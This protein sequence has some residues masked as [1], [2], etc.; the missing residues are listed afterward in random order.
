MSIKHFFIISMLLLTLSSYSAL[1]AETCYSDAIIKGDDYTIKSDCLAV[2]GDDCTTICS[3][4][5]ETCGYT[6]TQSVCDY[7]GSNYVIT[8]TCSSS[9]GTDSQDNDSGDNIGEGFGSDELNNSYG[10]NILASEGYLQLCGMVWDT[11]TLDSAVVKLNP[12]C[13]R[14]VTAKGN[15]TCIVDDEGFSWY[16]ESSSLPVIPGSNSSRA[17]LEAGLIVDNT[18]SQEDIDAGIACLDGAVTR[19]VDKIYPPQV[20]G[21]AGCSEL[22]CAK[23]EQGVAVC[24]N[25]GTRGGTG[26]FYECTV[27]DGSAH[28]ESRVSVLADTML[29]YS[30]GDYVLNCAPYNEFTGVNRPGTAS[31]EGYCE[32]LLIKGGSVD[33]I[34]VGMTS[35]DLSASDTLS[36]LFDEL[37]RL[38]NPETPLSTNEITT[39]LQTYFLV[40]ALDKKVVVDDTIPAVIFSD[41]DLNS[42]SA[43]GK[44]WDLLISLFSAKDPEV[45][46]DVAEQVFIRKTGLSTENYAVEYSEDFHSPGNNKWIIYSDGSK[47]EYSVTKWRSII[48]QR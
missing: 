44:L 34:I 41:K 9:Y 3:S 21:V 35:S 40:N 13:S 8:C 17:W 16:D 19:I 2:V 37:N 38:Y 46:S 29:S 30:S 33:Q 7:D 42:P 36:P 26:D 15:Y 47:D 6:N 43:F 28:W 24:V 32:L 18:Y 12:L 45:L 31:D 39:D 48:Q 23:E 22:R 5:N 20:L 10:T 4:V 25:E 14:L 27:R 1:A 11:S